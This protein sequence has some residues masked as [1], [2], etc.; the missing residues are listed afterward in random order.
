MM[1]H[2]LRW[3]TGAR[4]RVVPWRGDTSTAQLLPGAGPATASV[5]AEAVA[6]LA[7]TPYSFVLTAAISVA[8]QGPYLD[9]G[10][11][12]YE[13]LHLFVR[14]LDSLPDVPRHARLERGRRRDR[15]EI[16]ALDEAAFPPFWRLDE[17]GLDEA[18][19]A[20]PT[21]RLRVERDREIPG[22]LAGYAITGRSGPRGYIQRLA[23]SPDSQRRG[24]GTAL[25]D[26]GLRWLRRR[27]AREVLVNT[28]ESNEPAVELYEHLGFRR[29]R[30]G[31][32]VLRRALADA[33]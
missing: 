32:V 4:L 26:D 6:G 18:L 17:R 20:T 14:N 9:A 7:G 8:D 22:G 23:V 1:G 15:L 29:Q 5:V 21:A 12:P 31:L 25:V 2:R 30:E 3:G 33:S 24:I 28:Q 10:F 27:G 13:R 11:E 16:L 19:G